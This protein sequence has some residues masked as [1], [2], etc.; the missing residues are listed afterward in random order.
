MAPLFA[1][2]VAFEISGL[3]AIQGRL[4]VP[5]PQILGEGSIEGWPYITLAHLQGVP[6]QTICR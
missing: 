4:S 2:N 3:R 5:T 6:I 1:K